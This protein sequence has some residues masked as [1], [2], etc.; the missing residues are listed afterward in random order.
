MKNVK[1]AN[2]TASVVKKIVGKM[3]EV[4]CGAA[5]GWGMYQA[6]EPKAQKKV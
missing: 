4:S 1:K 6:K 2:R 5:S 3:A